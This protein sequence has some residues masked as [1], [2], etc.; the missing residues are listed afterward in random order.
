MNLLQRALG[1]PFVYNRIRPLAVGGIDYSRFYRGLEADRTSVI[2][3]I[4]CGTGNALGYLE[5]F[6]RYV[7]FD[8]DPTAV[9]FARTRHAARAN[10]S[11]ECRRLL[12][13]DILAIAPTHVTMGGLLHHL[14]DDEVLELLRDL[15]LSAGLKRVMALDIVY[16]PGKALNN[17]FARLD[18][19]RFCRHREQYESLVERSAFELR[20]SVLVRSHPLTGLV[21]YLIM[22]LEP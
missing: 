15:R 3:D 21:W 9:Q 1:N 12:A 18:R 22:K 5:D 2:V 14:S 10:V 8:T 4:G 13:E 11:F 20:E 19:G 7:G 17:L 6:V 16:L